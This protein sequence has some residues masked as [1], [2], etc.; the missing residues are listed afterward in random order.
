MSDSQTRV[1]FKKLR[2][3]SNEDNKLQRHVSDFQAHGQQANLTH[4]KDFSQTQ[5]SVQNNQLKN[6]CFTINLGKDEESNGKGFLHHK[7][8]SAS[9]KAST[10][11]NS[12]CN[13]DVEII[14]D[15]YAK[16]ISS[17]PGLMHSK[18]E[19]VSHQT[20]SDSMVQQPF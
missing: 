16:S 11:D 2:N 19:L 17:L 8:S 3:L 9:S 4:S 10:N 7:I 20:T 14:E 12:N 15:D 5:I 6:G 1:S 18:S 13:S